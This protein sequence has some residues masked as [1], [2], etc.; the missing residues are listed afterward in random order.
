LNNEECFPCDRFSATLTFSSVDNS[1]YLFGG[2]DKESTILKDLWQYSIQEQKWHCLYDGNNDNISAREGHAAVF[3]ECPT[4]STSKLC[5]FTK[6]GEQFLFSPIETAA[7]IV[8][9][10]GKG[11]QGFHHL[12]HDIVYYEIR[13]YSCNS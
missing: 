1:L 7:F 13:K 11:N 8:I 9:S 4:E 2:V 12:H 5:L 3:W 10:G 6:A